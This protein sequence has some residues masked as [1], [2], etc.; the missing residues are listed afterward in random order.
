MIRKL[1]A[2]IASM[3]LVLPASRGSAGSSDPAGGVPGAFRIFW[4]SEDCAVISETEGR[5]PCMVRTDDGKILYDQV[6]VISTGRY[7][8]IESSEGIRIMDREGRSHPPETGADEWNLSASDGK[9]G[10]FFGKAERKEDTDGRIFVYDPAGDTLTIL[11]EGDISEIYRDPDGQVY[12]LTSDCGIFRADGEQI[13]EK[14]RYEISLNCNF[15]ALTNEYLTVTDLDP[16]RYGSAVVLSPCT[17]EEICRFDGFTWAPYDANHETFRDNT[18]ILSPMDDENCPSGWGTR[19]IGLDGTVLKELTDGHVFSERGETSFLYPIDSL[20]CGGR[21]NMITDRTYWYD[22]GESDRLFYITCEETGEIFRGSVD[23]D[24]YVTEMQSLRTGKILSEEEIYADGDPIPERQEKYRPVNEREFWLR[25]VETDP[26]D[27]ASRNMTYGVEITSPDGSVLGGRSWKEI[28]WRNGI[29]ALEGY[30]VFPYTSV[31]AVQDGNDLFGVI[32]KNGEMVLPAEYEQVDC[33]GSFSDDP[34]ENGY[35]LAALKNSLWHVFDLQG[36]LLYTIPLPEPAAEETPEP[37]PEP[38]PAETVPAGNR[39]LPAETGGEKA[40]P[41]EG[42]LVTTE[43]NSMT[44]DWS[45]MDLPEKEEGKN[46]YVVVADAAN[47]YLIYCPAEQQTRKLQMLLTPGRVY[48]SGIVASAK[49]PDTLPLDY[50]VTKAPPAGK[51]TDHGFRPTVAAVAEMPADA[52]EGQEPE[53]VTEVTEELLRSGR[54][55]FRIEGAFETEE[56]IPAGKLLVTLT[57][58]EGNSYSCETA[59]DH[60][61]GRMKEDIPLTG[62]GLTRYPDRHGYPRGEYQLAYYLGGDLGDAFTFELK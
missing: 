16:D 62:S 38:A 17:G 57:D 41:L 34:K 1:M 43:K 56:E 6:N 4:A 7:A 35:C 44:V 61:A 14:G 3:V 24:G 18:A 10:L 27:P 23:E 15:D 54:A 60:T 33:I 48:V 53:P 25:Y 19:I 8:W 45:A 37:T 49:G 31:T 5:P 30:F 51:L 39:D 28:P 47:D 59:W 11:P 13:L 52:G 21:Y 12:I 20:G 32:S 36:D 29:E 55:Y 50:V 58:P 40:D 9:F 42:F 46:L 26:E 2:L 22:E